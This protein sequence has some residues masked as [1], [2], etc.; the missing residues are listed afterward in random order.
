MFKV[1]LQRMG[2]RVLT[3]AFAVRVKIIESFIVN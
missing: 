1:K 3:I 2:Y